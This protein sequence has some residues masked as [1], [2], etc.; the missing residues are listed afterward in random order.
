[1]F[2]VHGVQIEPVFQACAELGVD[3]VDTRHEASAGFAAEGYARLTG[4]LGVAAV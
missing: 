3:L 2:A 4:G 1:V